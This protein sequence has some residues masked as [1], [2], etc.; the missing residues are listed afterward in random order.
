MY[1]R[2]GRSGQNGAERH[3]PAQQGCGVGEPLELLALHSD[4]ASEP[5][6][7][8][9][10]RGDDGAKEDGHPPEEKEAD[11]FS[12]STLEGERALNRRVEAA[13]GQ[14]PGDD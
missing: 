2:S 12:Y 7:Q 5:E 8:G 3:S 13:L 9:E 10:C 14:E 6:H 4:G 11:R 1:N